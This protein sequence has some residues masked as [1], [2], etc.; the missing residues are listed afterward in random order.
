[1]LILTIAFP[2]LLLVTE[3]IKK[4][5]LVLSHYARKHGIMMPEN[6]N[7]IMDSRA[8]YIL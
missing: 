1:M 5:S 7:T 3:L 4:K 8:H 2:P 6:L